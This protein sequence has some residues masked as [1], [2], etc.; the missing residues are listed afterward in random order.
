MMNQNKIHSLDLKLDLKLKFKSVLK[1][2]IALIM[3]V[4]SQMVGCSKTADYPPVP[5]DSTS[6]LES[7]AK[8]YKA[9]SGDLPFS[10]SQMNAQAKKKFIIDVFHKAN[11]SYQKT[12]QTFQ[13]RE[14]KF[15]TK[16]IKDLAE[17]LSL[18]HNKLSSQ[19]KSELYTAQEL[20][21]IEHIDK[22]MR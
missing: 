6:A 8:A 21:A 17:L 20:T 5:L 7:L 2:S 14:N 3:L 9:E 1:L 11:F 4:A 19:S 13:Q 18:P 22:I 12:L 10:P 16:N 15:I